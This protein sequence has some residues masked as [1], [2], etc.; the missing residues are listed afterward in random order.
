MDN[1][2]ILTARGTQ[3]TLRRLENPKGQS[4]MDH[5]ETL[6]TLCIQ[7]TVRRLEK[8]KGPITNGQSRDTG[9]IGYTGY[10]TKV[11]E[12]QKGNQEGTIQRYW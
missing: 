6:V 7:D 10:S 3:D 11:R 1:P 8:A 12:H 4:R 5:P 9:N 2:E